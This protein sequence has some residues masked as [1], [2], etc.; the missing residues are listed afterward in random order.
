MSE[1]ILAINPGSTSTKFALFEGENIV[2]ERSV[3]HSS[4]KLKN[5]ARV[6]DQFNFRKEIILSEIAANGY[7][8][9]DVKAVVGRGG[10]L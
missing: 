9:E 10:L 4:N 8:K 1:Y 5:F 7:S 6:S 3:T 2:F